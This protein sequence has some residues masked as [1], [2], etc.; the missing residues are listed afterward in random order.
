MAACVVF[1]LGVGLQLDTKF[2]AFVVGRVIAGLGVGMVSCL[3]PMS[4][5]NLHFLL[6][7]TRLPSLL[8]FQLT[9]NLPCGYLRYQSE[10]APKQYR[11]FI[12]GLYQWVSRNSL[13][14]EGDRADASRR[15]LTF[16]FSLSSS[17]S[18]RLSPSD[19]CSPLSST[20]L[21]RVETATLLGSFSSSSSLSD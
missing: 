9:S 8:S 6:S 3:V 11:G 21:L 12:V 19:S 15:E 18:L 4:V 10:C 7:S 14:V 20:S 2:A 17:S 5:S 13:N 16:P 1:S